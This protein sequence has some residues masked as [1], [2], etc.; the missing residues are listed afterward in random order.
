M[1]NS[2]EFNI[3]VGRRIQGC[4]TYMDLRQEDL[5]ASLG[6][7]RSKLAQVETGIKEVRGEELVR[8][9][10]VLDVSVDY[11]LGRTDCRSTEATM[12]SAC[13]V[14]GLSERALKNI[15]LIRNLSSPDLTYN[16]DMPAGDAPRRY[17]HFEDELSASLSA[18]FEAGIPAEMAEAL[19]RAE[20]DAACWMARIRSGE[21]QPREEGF[22]R[23]KISRDLFDITYPVEY[24]AKSST[25]LDELEKML[26]SIAD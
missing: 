1:K 12:R 7:D 15:S 25:R 6:W 9:S 17:S 8:L 13:D 20:Q 22:V 14:T 11:L 26:D 21:L 23:K 3:G 5:A 24:I 10:E 19:Y 18:F 2:E 4:R 16:D